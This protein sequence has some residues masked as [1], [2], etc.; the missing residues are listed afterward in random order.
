MKF[1]VRLE[2]AYRKAKGLI[3]VKKKTKDGRDIT[4][5]VKP[6]ESA[7]D[8][9]RKWIVKT[10]SNRPAG[11][12]AGVILNDGGSVFDRRVGPDG[13][14]YIDYSDIEG[15][16][17]GKRLMIHN[18]TRDVGFS[19]QDIEML[20]SSGLQEMRVFYGKAEYSIEIKKYVTM[21][22]RWLFLERWYLSYEKTMNDHGISDNEAAHINMIEATKGRK[23]FYYERKNI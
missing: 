2:K 13:A 6:F 4:Y 3:P 7:V 16:L 5:W 21:N 8:K 19:Y 10:I 23:G 9:A 15:K 1:L 17:K 11:T 18:H 22:E 14:K 20:A 12:E